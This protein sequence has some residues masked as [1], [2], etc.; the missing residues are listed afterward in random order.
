MYFACSGL[1]PATSL[2]GIGRVLLDDLPRTLVDSSVILFDFQVANVGFALPQVHRVKRDASEALVFLEVAS[3]RLTRHPTW[4]QAVCPKRQPTTAGQA[5]KPQTLR[6][7]TAGSAISGL[8]GPAALWPASAPT[9]IVAGGGPALEKGQR[10]GK[11][12]ILFMTDPMH[13]LSPDFRAE[14]GPPAHLNGPDDARGAQGLFVL[15]ILV[16]RSRTLR[17]RRQLGATG[18]Y[19]ERRE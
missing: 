4:Q 19:Y 11:T 12:S 15:G 2:G 8:L 13:Y 18:N 9:L 14:S 5:L 10:R 16:S 1:N 6:P 3:C 7:R 17:S